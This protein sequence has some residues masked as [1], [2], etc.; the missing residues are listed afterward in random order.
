M[1]SVEFCRWDS[2]YFV[3][4]FL[5]LGLLCSSQSFSH[6]LLSTGI[7]SVCCPPLLPATPT[8]ESAA[9]KATVREQTFKQ[10]F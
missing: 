5:R 6:S 7:A 2:M 4:L 1:T 9:Q 3:G 8:Q 10:D